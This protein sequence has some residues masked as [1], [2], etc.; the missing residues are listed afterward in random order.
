MFI[1]GGGSYSDNFLTIPMLQSCE[2]ATPPIL[3]PQHPVVNIVKYLLNQL[4][5]MEARRLYK[6]G[7]NIFFNRGIIII[8]YIIEPVSIGICAP[9]AEK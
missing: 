9:Y 6:S 5:N 4:S 1:L 8:I 7:L 3:Q 2:N